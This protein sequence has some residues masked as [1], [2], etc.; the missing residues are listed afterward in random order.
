MLARCRR[1]IQLRLVKCLQGRETPLGRFST[2]YKPQLAM[3]VIARRRWPG[4]MGLSH[5]TMHLRASTTDLFVPWQCGAYTLSHRVVLPALSLSLAR[6]H[7]VPTPD[8]A[9]FYAR[10]TTPGGLVVCETASVSAG[11]ARP[12]APGLHS[13][14]QVNHWRLVTDAVHEAGGVAVAQLG[15]GGDMVRV[16]GQAAPGLDEDRMEQFLL[17]YRSAAENASDAGFDGVELQAAHG[18]LPVR[19]LHGELPDCAPAYRDSAEKGFRFLEEALASLVGV[20]GRDRVG[21]CLA[22]VR[23]ENGRRLGGLDTLAFYSRL[24]RHVDSIGIAWLQV[25]EPGY[26]G[27]LPPPARPAL[28]RMSTLLRPY[29]PGALVI[30]GGLD[31]RSAREELRSG[32]AQGVAFGRSFLSDA[33]L[34]ARLRDEASAQP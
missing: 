23:P 33:N 16:P 29:F 6:T 9:A 3:N 26:G 8:M 1:S 22:P 2:F 5:R 13:A 15:L 4:S 28:P 14:E 12:D 32:R 24:L 19:L 30:A 31:G 27:V 11:M 10:R 20:W 17:D 34:V 18:A 25:V 21:L 7:G